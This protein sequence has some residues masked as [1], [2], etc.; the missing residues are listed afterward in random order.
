[1]RIAVLGATGLVGRTM[2]KLLESFAWVDAPPLALASPRSAGQRVPWRG[3]EL[4][5]RAVDA[6]CF[7]GVDLALFSA[8]GGPSREWA[9]VAAAAGAVVIDNSSAWR[10]DPDIALVVPEINGRLVD[11][12]RAGIIANP[13]CSTIQVAQAVAPLERAWGLDEVHVTTFQAVSGAGQKAVA[14]LA[15]QS[16]GELPAGNIFPRPIAGNVIPAIGAALDD[17]SY[18]EEAKVLRE[19][20]KILGRDESLKVTCTAVRVPVANGHSAAVRVVC[21]SPVTPVQACAAMAAWPGLEVA[22]DPCDYATPREIDGRNIVHVG[23]LRQDPG[24]PQA[25]LCWVVADNVLKGAAWNA[26]QIAARVA[27]KDIA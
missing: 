9:P 17:G 26:V 22:A 15:R 8:G 19:L 3:G 14:E 6:A 23:R 4:T 21:A 11:G 18:E 27:G 25:L 7:A 2:L 1:M 5:C 16:A 12:M 10:Q 13:N 20:R 24:D